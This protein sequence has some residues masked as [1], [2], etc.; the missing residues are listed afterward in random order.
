MMRQ[1]D[2]MQPNG[3]AAF[4]L[5]RQPREAPSADGLLLEASW[6]SSKA[7]RLTAAAQPGP[8]IPFHS[9]PQPSLWP[10][11]HWALTTS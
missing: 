9:I 10:I 8:L 2:G 4:E 7:A 6:G 3:T 11:V 1:L 5:A